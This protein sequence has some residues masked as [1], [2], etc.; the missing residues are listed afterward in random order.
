MQYAVLNEGQF[1]CILRLIVGSFLFVDV[2][3]SDSLQ[4]I[5]I[6]QA[7]NGLSLTK[8]AYNNSSLPIFGQL[9]HRIQKTML[10]IS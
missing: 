9:K 2:I 3:A 7:S 6:A 5:I 8:N 10:V 1:L 4:Q